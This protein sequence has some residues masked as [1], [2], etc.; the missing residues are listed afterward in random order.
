MKNKIQHIALLLLFSVTSNLIIAQAKPHYQLPPYEK[1][2]LSNGLMVYI[3]EKHEVPVISMEFV[4]PAAAINDGDKAGL[5]SLTVSC[6]KCGT[7]NYTKKEIEQQFDFLGASLN[8]YSETE[9]AGVGTKFA[10]K[11][12]DKVLPLV[13]EI[14]VNPVFSEE[15]FNKEKKRTLLSLDQ[16]KESPGWV[17]SSY[18]KKFYYGN[19]VY[20]NVVRGTVSSVNSLTAEDAKKFYKTYY[21]PEGSALAVVGDFNSSQM[22][23]VLTTL[24]ADWKSSGS[25]PVSQAQTVAAPASS[26]VLLVNKNDAHETTFM[27]GS[28]GVSRHS[29]DYIPLEVVNTFFGGKFTSWLN[30]ELRIKSGLTYGAGSHFEYHRDNG[31]FLIS[32]HTANKT[33]KPAIDKALEVINRLHSQTIDEETLTSAKNY[34]IGMLPPDYQS[35]NQLAVL[36]TNMFWYGY[37]ESY[38]NNFESNVKGVTVE[39]AKEVIAKYFPKDKLQFVLI[40]KSADIK[41]IA[42]K[43]GPV[44]EVQIKDDI[45]KGF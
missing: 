41:K 16:A 45:G 33:T 34:M 4:L 3:M 26:R 25:S 12:Q 43:Y 24:F 20:G 37:N 21:R 35:T 1:F 42:E 39:K 9:T 29:A 10:A 22:K 27:I 7:K 6:L 2:K 19:N 32:T 36:L 14:L 44:R 40:G 18:W 31:S 28:A 38:I 23:A 17:I 11:D 30:S 8:L 13:K 5:A 15:E